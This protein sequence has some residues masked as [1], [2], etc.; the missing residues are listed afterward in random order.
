MARC[1][2]PVAR[3]DSLLVTP[4]CSSSLVAGSTLVVRHSSL[5]TRYPSSPSGCTI[6]LPQILQ[7]KGSLRDPR[8][9]LYLLNNKLRP[10]VLPQFILHH[11]LQRVP[12]V[13]N[14]R[15]LGHGHH[16]QQPAAPCIQLFFKPDKP[17]LIDPGFPPVIGDLFPLNRRSLQDITGAAVE[18]FLP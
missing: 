12:A 18:F 11:H 3:R 6:P 10:G 14:P 5:V 15:H 1:S 8:V 13:F 9:K 16:F 4:A 2:S 7:G 17:L